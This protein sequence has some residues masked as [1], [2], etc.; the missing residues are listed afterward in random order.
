MKVFFYT[1]FAL[2]AF[3]FNSILCRL[4]LGA[5]TIDAASFTTV[6]L[7]SGAIALVLISSFLDKKES[8]KTRKLDF[9][10]FSFCLRD[11]FFVCL[12]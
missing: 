4:A 3:A 6:R 1:A 10:V 9:R 5:Q 11:L 7:I 2:T 8:K 12:R